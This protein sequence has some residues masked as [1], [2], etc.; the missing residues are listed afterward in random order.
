MAPRT[1]CKEVFARLVQFSTRPTG[2]GACRHRQGVNLQQCPTVLLS[3]RQRSEENEVVG[4][5]MPQAL[6]TEPWAR[7]NSVL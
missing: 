3:I 6:L 7:K 1:V 5:E 4:S 2:S